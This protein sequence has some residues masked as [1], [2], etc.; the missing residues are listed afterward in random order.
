MTYDDFISLVMLSYSDE[1]QRLTLR[2]T[3]RSRYAERT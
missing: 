3:V 2:T 1:C